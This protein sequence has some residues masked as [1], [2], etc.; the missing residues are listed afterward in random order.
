M[1]VMPVESISYNT[2]LGAQARSSARCVRN[3]VSSMVD[4][5]ERYKKRQ[6]CYG[7]ATGKGYG[8]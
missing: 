7:S 5:T 1:C 3:L 4:G 6:A 2:S 8:L